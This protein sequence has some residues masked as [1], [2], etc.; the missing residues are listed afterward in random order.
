MSHEHIQCRRI[1]GTRSSGRLEYI[2]KFFL[3]C[4]IFGALKADVDCKRMS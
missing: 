2:V 1:F 4:I 3:T